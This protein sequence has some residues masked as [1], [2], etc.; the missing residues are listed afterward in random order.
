MEERI[1]LVGT[2]DFGSRLRIVAAHRG[3]TMPEAM[4]KYLRPALD[5]EYRKVLEE[6]D[7]ADGAKTGA[8]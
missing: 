7:K 4:E 8:K 2:R 1:T 3:L 6:V 5:R